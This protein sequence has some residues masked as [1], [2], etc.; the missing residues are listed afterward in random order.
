MDF[1]LSEASERLAHELL[2]LPPPV[3][4][5]APEAEPAPTAPKPQ[6][7]S[8]PKPALPK[9]HL[10]IV[11]IN[12]VDRFVCDVTGRL[13]EKRIVVP[14]F[15]RH[16][17][18]SNV[19]CAVYFVRTQCTGGPEKE[20]ELLDAIAERYEQVGELPQ[21][22]SPKQ[23]EEFGGRL[24]YDQWI[25][26]LD[27]WDQFTEEKGQTV[28]EHRTAPKRAKKKARA[29][30]KQPVKFVFD[31]K[32][33]YLIKH[34]SAKQTA[35]VECNSLDDVRKA[36][37]SARNWFNR[38]NVEEQ[39]GMFSQTFG[40]AGNCAGIYNTA[41]VGNNGLKSYNEVAWRLL[42]DEVHGPAVVWAHKKF[43]LVFD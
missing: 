17:S 20:Q 4:E 42:G 29:K 34:T 30:K 35:I 6:K 12:G 16:L 19:P 8:R 37:R 24:S 7:R 5:A 3:P 41:P 26:E 31:S 18:F 38:N 21:T 39:A 15:E 43:S 36:L 9:P 27:K 28:E 22:P 23:L 33:V 11:S 32:K 40:D 10:K 14:G 13:L 1:S 2:D 25:G